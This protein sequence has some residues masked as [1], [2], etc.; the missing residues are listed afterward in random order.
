MSQP[1]CL[2]CGHTLTILAEPSTIH[3]GIDRTRTEKWKVRKTCDLCLGSRKTSRAPAR[4]Q[5][6]QIQRD[7]RLTQLDHVRIAIDQALHKILDMGEPLDDHRPRLI[8]VL[9]DG[10]R[11]LHPKGDTP[12]AC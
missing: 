5:L 3:G 12:D 1:V 9:T 4:T 11:S 10:L 7:G 8:T 6:G 2:T